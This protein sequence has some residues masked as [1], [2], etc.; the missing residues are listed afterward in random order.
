MKRYL[1]DNKIEN[2]KWVL[3]FIPKSMVFLTLEKKIKFKGKN[4]KT[5][6][7]ID[8]LHKMVSKCYFSK[9]CEVKLSSDLLRHWYGSSYSMYLEY[10]INYGI[11][12]KVGN[13]QVGVNSNMYSLNIPLSENSLDVVRFK[14]NNGFILKKWKQQQLTM[15][16]NGLN[17][18]KTIE[19][20]IKKKLIE[21]LY[22]VEIDY[23]KASE[24]LLEIYINNGEETDKSYWKN[25]MNI[26]SIY[27]GSLFYVEDDYGRLHTNFTVLK[28]VLR[29]K[30]IKIGGEE[31]CE[32][33][34]YNSQ[35]LLLCVLL[36]ENGFD[37]QYPEAYK[38]YLKVVKEGDI[39]K[40]LANNLG[41]DRCKCKKNIFYFLFGENKWLNTV[42]KEFKKLFPEVYQW[43]RN[44]KNGLDDYKAIAHELQR[45][46]SKLIFGSIIRILKTRIPDIRLF[47][48]H[49]SIIFPKKYEVKAREIFYNQVDLLFA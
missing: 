35:P 33:D 21:D 10:L 20:W 26:E 4:L 17:D 12:Q 7:L 43:V 41:I 23:M 40:L 32:L 8:I 3:Q 36:K 16:I 6:Y 13:Y 27:D 15:E 2:K 45:R 28:K 39:Y 25:M 5:A 30:H 1:S 48:V 34:L 22:Y 24:E 9:K 47:T 18:S 29:N 42:D 14:N 46:E 11:M 49:D 38:K 31:V 44:Y 37:E 19:P